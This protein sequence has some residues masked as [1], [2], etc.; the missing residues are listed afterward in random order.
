MLINREIHDEYKQRP[1][2]KAVLEFADWC[3]NEVHGWRLDFVSRNEALKLV[4]QVTVRIVNR[5][6]NCHPDADWCTLSTVIEVLRREIFE[7]FRD[8]YDGKIFSGPGLIGEPALP[9]L[10][11][12]KLSLG[13]LEEPG[14][15]ENVLAKKRDAWPE[16]DHAG[17]DKFRKE[18]EGLS[19]VD[20]MSEI[21][22][23]FCSRGDC[24]A[25]EGNLNLW[26]TWTKDGGWKA[27]ERTKLNIILF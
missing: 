24:V 9:N 8:E 17:A 21:E 7:P 4:E 20:K 25:E 5:C 27:P 26:V 22:V 10:K 16:L 2:T 13:I 23:Y 3:D 11:T 18:L 19:K 14:L 6:H 15:T 1:G 12:I